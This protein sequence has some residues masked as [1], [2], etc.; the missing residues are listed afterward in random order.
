MIVVSLLLILVAVTLLALGLA[1]GSSPLLISSIV[2]SLL[3]AVALVVGARQAATQ[4]RRPVPTEPT[5]MRPTAAA[6]ARRG[7]RRRDPVATP[8]VGAEPG[9]VR[10]DAHSDF[11]GSDPILSDSGRSAEADSGASRRYP[12]AE[13]GPAEGRP[14]SEPDPDLS[15]EPDSGPEDRR[16]SPDAESVSAEGRLPEDSVAAHGSGAASAEPGPDPRNAQPTAG[17][18]ATARPGEPGRAADEDFDGLLADDATTRPISES[19]AHAAGRH[20]ADAALAGDPADDYTRTTGDADGYRGEPG[21]AGAS[22]VAGSSED[23]RPRRRDP[24]AERS[25]AD[26]FSGNPASH[27]APP[28]DPAGA[29]GDLPE[30]SA[31]DDPDEDDPADEPAPQSVSPSDAVRVARMATEVLVVDGRPRYHLAGCPHLAGRQTEPLPANEAVELGFSPC[32]Q[33]RPVDRLVA[34]ATH[35]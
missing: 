4:H 20:D 7:P 34:Q 29:P 14:S 30:T 2:A 6:P 35:R 13:S 15:S 16:R 12:D 25:P 18:A 28:N 11:S 19:D 26:Q 5:A 24:D 10:G 8:D 27:A 9:T 22:T 17:A 3:A 23:G 1:G 33:C 32:G 31:L 21:F